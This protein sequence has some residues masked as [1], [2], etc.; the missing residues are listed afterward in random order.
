MVKNVSILNPKNC[1]YG[2]PGGTLLEKL[3]T[4]PGSEIWDPEKA[5]PDPNPRVK[6]HRNL[7]RNNGKMYSSSHHYTF[8]FPWHGFTRSEGQI[9]IGN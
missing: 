9:R 4:D 5:I 2:V 3:V 1:Y 7:D 8:L 6:K